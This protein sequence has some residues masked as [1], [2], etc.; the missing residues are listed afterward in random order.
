MKRL[1]KL[2]FLLMG[3]LLLVWAVRK[4]DL[5]TV[6]VLLLEMGW[7]FIVVV[8]SYGLMAGFDAISW[9]FAFKPEEAPAMRYWELWR[10]RTI[11]E[12]FNAITPFGTMGGEPVKAQLLKDH[13]RLT[14]KQG[15][16]SQVVARTTLLVA[17][18]IFLLPGTALLFNSPVVPEDFKQ[19]S[20]IGLIT[21]SILIFL[22]LLFQILGGLGKITSWFSARFPGDALQGFIS[23]TRA[24]D[25]M[26]SDYYKKHP[27][28]F[29][30][31]TGFGGLGWMAGLVE[32]Y[33][34]LYFLGHLVGIPELWIIE[35]LTQLIR[36][37]S[38]FIPLS[39]GAQEGGLVLIFVALGLGGDLGLAVAFVRRLREFLWIGLGL[40]LG[41]G[42]AFKPS[43]VQTESVEKP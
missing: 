29:L 6:T 39:L 41:W 36:A 19:V 8:L 4:V 30:K 24:L 22:F 28:R 10:I 23:H 43:D 21:F 7:G 31:S 33:L 17:L 13:H 20:L 1:V 32:L 25:Q 14:F 34:T 40:L 37:G 15:L 11:G 3:V 26:M 12:S 35:A 2:T 9:K 16:A 27:Y 38:F 5:D 42:M 18:I